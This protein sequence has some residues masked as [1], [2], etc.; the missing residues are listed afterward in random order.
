MTP[1][2]NLYFG[3]ASTPFAPGASPVATKALYLGLVISKPPA[4]M[5][6]PGRPGGGGGGGGLLASVRTASSGAP[7]IDGNVRTFDATARGGR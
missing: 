4:T 1:P 2:T 5:E 6:M 3:D 7:T